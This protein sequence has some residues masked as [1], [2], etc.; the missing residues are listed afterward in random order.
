VNSCKRTHAESGM[1][2]PTSRP[3]PW[4]V[5]LEEEYSMAPVVLSMVGTAGTSARHYVRA[6][7]RFLRRVHKPEAVRSEAEG[8]RVVIL[9]Q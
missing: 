8:L 9:H 1:V 4:S 2:A 3:R 6:R 5:S 7:R